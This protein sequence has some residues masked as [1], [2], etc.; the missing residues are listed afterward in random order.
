MKDLKG[1]P[2]T[3]NLKRFYGK[4]PALVE[5]CMHSGARVPQCYKAMMRLDIIVPDSQEADMV[6]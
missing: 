6:A 1:D 5:V 2:L 4:A 3:G